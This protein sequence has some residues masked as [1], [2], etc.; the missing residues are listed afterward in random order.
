MVINS[1]LLSSHFL[2]DSFTIYRIFYDRCFSFSTLNSSY[3]Y[4]LV[5]MASD[6]KS[7]ENPLYV[8]CYTYLAIFKIFLVFGYYSL[9]ICLLRFILFGVYWVSWICRFMSS[10]K[11]EKFVVIISPYNYPTSFVL[12]S[13]WNSHNA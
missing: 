8:T 10:L 2:K 4:F 9:I 6:E 13:L 11:F 7:P 5:S 12:F 3:R 1:Q